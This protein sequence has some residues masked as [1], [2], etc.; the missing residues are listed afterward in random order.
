MS[1]GS[2]AIACLVTGTKCANTRK[3]SIIPLNWKR[4]NQKFSISLSPEILRTFV[5]SRVD[6]GCLV[7][8]FDPSQYYLSIRV[9]HASDLTSLHQPTND[10]SSRIFFCS[11]ARKGSCIERKWV[12]EALLRPLIS[13]LVGILPLQTSHTRRH[14][15]NCIIP[16]SNSTLHSLVASP[17]SRILLS[18]CTASIPSSE[19]LL[20]AN[21]V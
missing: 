20:I 18:S 3:L 2:T 6:D 13:R 4:S 19:P 17:K 12:R 15:P 16:Q 11:R 10:D 14:H 7:W 9:P 5:A 21:L 1:F 8:S